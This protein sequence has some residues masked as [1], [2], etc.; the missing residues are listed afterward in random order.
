MC[1][2]ES[3]PSCNPENANVKDAFTE[4][5]TK[6]GQLWWRRGGNCDEGAFDDKEDGGH[7]GVEVLWS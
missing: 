2:V 4:P 3:Y 7:E 1:R 6:A 5:A